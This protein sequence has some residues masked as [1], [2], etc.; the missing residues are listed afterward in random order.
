MSA[1]RVL[2][3]LTALGAAGAAATYVWAGPQR[4]WTNWLWVLLLLTTVGLGCLFIVALERVVGAVWS[5]PVRRVPERLSSLLLAALPMAIAL[6]TALP[7]LYP[8][9]D[10]EVLEKSHFVSGK[11]VW[12]NIPFFSIRLLLC[13]ALWGLSWW[14]LVRG[15]LRQDRTRDPAFSLRARKLSGA[16][17]FVFAITVTLVAF[18]WV[19]S[20]EPEWY[21]DI[22][23]VYLFAGTFL[24]G[25]AAT[26]LGVLHLR[27]RGRLPGVKSDHLYNLGGLMF[28]FTVFW[29]YIAFAQYMLMWYANMPEE[30][31]WY[32]A[33]V[34]GPWR[35][36]ILLLAGLHFVL[37][38]FVLVARDAKASP[39][40][41]RR[42]A[43]VI[44]GAH[45]LD[46][47]WL[48]FPTL[49]RGVLFSWP[50]VSF[51]LLALGVGLLVARRAMRAGEDMP[52]GDPLLPQGLEFRL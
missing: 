23:G 32:Q 51:A 40:A 24:A 4:F 11:A 26:A 41:L 15:S 35:P 25:L 45:A 3:G 31:F 2:W 10:P 16:F 17:L 46:L 39:R 37:P 13:C 38:F 9:T 49:R 1:G 33:R 5:V 12:L 22:F 20:L 28:A 44:L 8:W 42:M 30:I 19:S 36:V 7:V 29:S 47:Y 18:D 50:E 48:V 43:V 21:S 34:D 27:D 14:L 52:A 6:L